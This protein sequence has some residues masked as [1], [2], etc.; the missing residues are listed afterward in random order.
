MRQPLLHVSR[1][2][3]FRKLCDQF[4]SFLLAEA[5]AHAAGRRRG[6]SHFAI[7]NLLFTPKD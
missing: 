1:K 3:K 4:L 2:R 7:A 5:A 6:K